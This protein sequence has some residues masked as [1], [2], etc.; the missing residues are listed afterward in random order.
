MLKKTESVDSAVRRCFR[1]KYESE[2]AVEVALSSA[3]SF[4][5]LATSEQIEMEVLSQWLKHDPNKCPEEVGAAIISYAYHLASSAAPTDAPK[6]GTPADWASTLSLETIVRNAD[7][8]LGVISDRVIRSLARRTST[9]KQRVNALTKKQPTKK[10]CISATECEKM[11]HCLSNVLLCEMNFIAL[12]SGGIEG[13][14]IDK[15]LLSR[16]GSTA[17]VALIYCSLAK[18]LGLSCSVTPLQQLPLVRVETKGKP[19]FVNLADGGKVLT[20]SGATELVSK[21]INSSTIA[22]AALQPNQD[23]KVPFC[24]LLVSVLQSARLANAAAEKVCKAQLLFLA[25]T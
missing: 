23:P 25:Q 2:E 7:T 4:I 19:L 15:V 18:R 17:M 3:F 6:R 24:L 1:Q 16:T 10:C 11:L 9:K 22:K 8:Q 20:H 21:S 12:N 14:I 5:R 13:F